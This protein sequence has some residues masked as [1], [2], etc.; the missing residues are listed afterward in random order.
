MRYGSFS[1]FKFLDNINTPVKETLSDD[2]TASFKNAVFELKKLQRNGTLEW[3]KFKDTRITH[4]SQVLDPL[5]RL[6]IP[7]G[8]G[9]HCINA[10]K[11]NHG[12]SWRMIVSLT[13]QTEAYGVYPGGQSGNPGSKY[14]DN[15]IDTWAAGKYNILWVM[16]S[17]E[18][19][20]QKVKY[21]MVFNK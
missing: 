13:P 4:L 2:I 12:P 21:T 20:D 11:Q 3:G 1:A 10:A 14:Y 5:S 15:F 17:S 16:K 6:H 18:T 19:Q 9:V 7:I 8:G